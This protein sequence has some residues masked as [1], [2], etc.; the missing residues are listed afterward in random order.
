M[1]TVLQLTNEEIIYN[2]KFF[3]QK[4]LVFLLVETIDTVEINK[5]NILDAFRK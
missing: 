5:V 2:L 4:Y 1:T 3:Y